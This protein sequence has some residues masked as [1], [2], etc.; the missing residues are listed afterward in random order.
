[1]N[2]GIENKALREAYSLLRREAPLGGFN[3]GRLCSAACCAGN[4]GEGMWLFPHEAELFVKSDGFTIVKTES[5]F[6]YP[7]L[8]C[9]GVCNRAERPLA[10]RFFPLFPALIE[11]NGEEKIKIIRDP[12][13]SMCPLSLENTRIDRS[14][15]RNVKL[16]GK[17]LARDVEIHEYLKKLSG[18]LL[19]IQKFREL[20]LKK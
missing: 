4:E 1:M 11:E 6:G 7:L 18:E 5:N 14:F 16:A 17:F 19:E 15:V 3:C 13:A 9:R 20:L 8:V 2:Y 10:C 12:R